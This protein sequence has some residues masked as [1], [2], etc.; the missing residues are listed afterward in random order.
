MNN[1]EGNK[2][3]G[4]RANSL[5]P[6]KPKP[7]MQKRAKGLKVKV[8]TKVAEVTTDKVEKSQSGA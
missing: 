4:G 6:N 3:S 2:S 5:R 8:T 1:K 7:A